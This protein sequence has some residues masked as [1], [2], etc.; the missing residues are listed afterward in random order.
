[1]LKTPHRIIGTRKNGRWKI[2]AKQGAYSASA[3]ADGTKTGFREASEKARDRLAAK[4][5]A[6]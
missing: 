6:N 1:M 3:T 5:R 2:T 4:M